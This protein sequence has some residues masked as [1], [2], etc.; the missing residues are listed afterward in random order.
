MTQIVTWRSSFLETLSLEDDFLLEISEK[1]ITILKDVKVN[2]LSTHPC[3]KIRKLLDLTHSN[4]H[5]IAVAKEE[6]GVGICAGT[7]LAG[8]N[9]AMLIQSTGLGN[10]VNALC[11][12]TFTYRLPLLI[13]A[14]WRG[15][16]NEKIS[17][18]IPLGK[19]LPKILEALGINFHTVSE[20]EDLDAI[21]QIAQETYASNTQGVILL[22]PQVWEHETTLEALQ[23][24]IEPSFTSFETEY[25]IPSPNERML[26]RFEIL[27]TAAPFLEDK[28][29]ICNI[30]MPS[31][32]LYQIKHQPS[33][34]YMLGS[35]GLASSIGLG[36]ALFTKRQVV[37]IDGD[38]S[39]LA[40][41][42]AMATIAQA[43][44]PNLSILA[45]DN[46]VHGSTGNQL[47]ATSACVDLSLAVRGLGINR[48]FR[49]SKRE[50]LQSILSELGE[51]PNFIHTLARAGNAQVP[52]IPR[53]P[54]DIKQDFMREVPKT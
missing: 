11:S 25:T 20:P 17:A 2:F 53:T 46:G 28:L 13:L 10:M 34:F 1:I 26:T 47:T 38:G 19:R 31:R 30:G 43:A 21:T 16:Y 29:V 15:V 22:S 24:R 5:S 8:K 33:N 39:L 54:L 44:P 40:N 4:F 49:T 35:L 18:Q 7:T 41:L 3:A 27:Q 6:E 42:G 52:T 45:I 14:S 12:L 32:E 9:S 50:E 51:G 48:V 37:V 23:P 36:V